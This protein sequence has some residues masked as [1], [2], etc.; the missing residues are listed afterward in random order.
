MIFYYRPSESDPNLTP[1]PV[2][3]ERWNLLEKRIIN[4]VLNKKI[5]KSFL[6]QII[7]IQKLKK[8][9]RRQ[10]PKYK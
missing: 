5:R 7:W 2:I 8:N 6:K 3:Q 4:I 10:I 1:Q 9:R